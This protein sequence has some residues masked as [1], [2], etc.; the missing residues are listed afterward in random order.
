MTERSNLKGPDTFGNY[1]KYIFIKKYLT[2][3]ATRSW[4]IVYNIVS[5]GSLCSNVV[6]EKEV[7][8]HS[9]INQ[10]SDF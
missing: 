9:K 1:L 6:F 10:T 5:N 2:S 4:W 8:S 7:I 3:N